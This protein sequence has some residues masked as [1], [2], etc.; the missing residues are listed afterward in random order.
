MKMK[1]K[2]L[3]LKLILHLDP[4]TEAEVIEFLLSA[5]KRIPK[6]SADDSPSVHLQVTPAWSKVSYDSVRWVVFH[7][8]PC[9][10][11]ES[12]ESLENAL[13]KL[14]AQKLP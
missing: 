7:G 1:I 10:L 14:S 9:V 5:A 13:T 6:N 4:I 8:D 12:S 2:K 11:A 3:L